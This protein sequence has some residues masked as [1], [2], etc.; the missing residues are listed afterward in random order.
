ML[1][2]DFNRS[3]PEQSAACK[4]MAKAAANWLELLTGML[5]WQHRDMPLLRLKNLAEVAVRMQRTPLPHHTHHADR[6][7]LD[8]FQEV[9]FW[10]DC[11]W[12]MLCVCLS[13]WVCLLMFVCLLTHIDTRHVWRC[14][15]PQLD[16]PQTLLCPLPPP[17][18]YM[19]K[20][21]TR[22]T[23]HNRC[24]WRRASRRCRR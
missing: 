7:L 12:C 10:C 19:H 14:F 18:P 22:T 13:A 23:P 20:S 3:H 1:C 17:P 4:Q 16:P 6:D 15:A 21:Q 24:S 8:F 5:L 9:G 2:T 11:V